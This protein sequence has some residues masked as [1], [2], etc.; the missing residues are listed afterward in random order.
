MSTEGLAAHLEERL[1]EAMNDPPDVRVLTGGAEW[2]HRPSSFVHWALPERTPEEQAVDRLRSAGFEHT[3][4]P[5]AMP[6]P[7]QHNEFR[8]QI[9]TDTAVGLGLIDPPEGWEPWT[10]PPVPWVTRVRT[11]VRVLVTRVRMRLASALAGFDVE[12]RE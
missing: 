2:N 4:W 6:R 11:R 12:D 10:P 8:F 3:G 1:R 7:I 9:S 5:D